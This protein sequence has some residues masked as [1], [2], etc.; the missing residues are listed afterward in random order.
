MD[1]KTDG[2]TMETGNV[3]LQENEVIDEELFY[4]GTKA[5]LKP[6][7]CEK[8]RNSLRNPAQSYHR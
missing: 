6:G 8:G 5:E 2:G 3:L 1:K 7:N 4:H